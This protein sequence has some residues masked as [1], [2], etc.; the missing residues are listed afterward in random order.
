MLVL[1]PITGQ[2]LAAQYKGPYK[3]TRQVGDTDYLID[4]PN[5]RKSHQLCHIN[6][7]KPYVRKEELPANSSVVVVHGSVVGKSDMPQEMVGSESGIESMCGVNRDGYF[8]SS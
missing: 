7:L 1:L 3:V 4:A 6:M 8:L 2:S 5:S